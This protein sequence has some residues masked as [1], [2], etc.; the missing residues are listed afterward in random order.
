MRL[1]KTSALLILTLSVMLACKKKCKIENVNVNSG[2][3]IENVVLYPSSGNMTGNMNGNYIINA[4]SSYKDRFEMSQNNGP[5]TAVNYANFTILAFPVKVK[6]NSA[7]ERNVT[8]DNAA[9]TVTYKMVIT[10]CD[11]CIQEYMTENYVLVPSFPSNYT[12]L[13]DLSIIDK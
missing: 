3:I 13:Y 10:Q 6:C 1:F 11:N 2:A 8:I 7:Y 5:R 9:M 12:V 4:S